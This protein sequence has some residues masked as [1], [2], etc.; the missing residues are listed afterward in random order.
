[1]KDGTMRLL[2][3]LLVTFLTLN[4]RAAVW[5]TREQWTPEWEKKFGAWVAGP[6]WHKDFFV[7]AGP[8][9]GLKLDCADAVYSMR[10]IFAAK[11]GLPFVIKDPTGG[12]RKITNEMGR[13]DSQSANQKL[14]SFVTYIY[15]VTSTRSLP[16]D[17]YPVEVSRQ[18]MGAGALILTDSKSRH[19]WTVKYIS[20]TGVPFLLS[21]S[22]PPT[23]PMFEH[24]E[25]PPADY[26][27]SGGLSPERN[28]GFRRFRQPAY[29]GKSAWEVP[30]YSTE[31]YKIPLSSWNET[32]QRKLATRSETIEE[33]MTR[34]L[35]GTCRLARDRALIVGMGDRFLSQMNK[36]CMNDTQYDDYSTPG[37]DKRLKMTFSEFARDAQ[38]SQGKLSSTLEAKINNVMLGENSVNSS[39]AYCPV[40]IGAGLNLTLGQVYERLIEGKFSTSPH[41]TLKMRWGFA[42]FPGSRAKT[43]GR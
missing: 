3:A 20:D 27:F 17:T 30:G 8:L 10:L 13:W 9:Q 39:L 37:R 4:S 19:T 23:T 18:A 35:E 26:V 28:S 41:D 43:C 24:Y 11:H 14:R 36:T 1:M 32:M 2:L 15:G 5:Q 33:R 40:S 16:N 29:I 6:E 34:L 22:L 21:R 7:Q 25:F 12:S 31:Q 38:M 42:D